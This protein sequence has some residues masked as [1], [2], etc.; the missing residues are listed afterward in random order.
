MDGKVLCFRAILSLMKTVIQYPHIS[1]FPSLTP[2]LAPFLAF[3]LP[4]SFLL[5]YNAAAL[6]NK[7]NCVFQ[8]GDPGKAKELYLEALGVEAD[9]LEGKYMCSLLPLTLFPYCFICQTKPLL[10]LLLA[11]ASSLPPPLPSARALS[12]SIF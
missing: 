2:S 3:S 8:R 10:R 1:F 5:R 9:C 4:Q 7:A 11:L 6:V 12:R